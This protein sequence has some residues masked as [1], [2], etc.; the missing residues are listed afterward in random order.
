MLYQKTNG[1]WPKNYDMQAI[2]TGEQKTQIINSKNFLNTC[3]DNSA[4]FSHLNYL[5]KAFGLSKNEKYKIAFID[6]IKF[7][8]ICTIR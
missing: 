6:G 5:G 7:Y 8:S 4:T 1:G 2:L 3:F